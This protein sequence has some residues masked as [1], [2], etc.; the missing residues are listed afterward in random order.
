MIIFDANILTWSYGTTTNAPTARHFYTAT[1][2]SDGVIVYLGG[3]NDFDAV[4]IININ[5]INLYDTKSDSWNVTVY[6]EIFL[7]KY[8]KL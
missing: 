8:I 6:N 2:L 1:L 3:S 5:E 4:E 7:F